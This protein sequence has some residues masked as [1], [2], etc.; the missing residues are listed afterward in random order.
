M[1]TTPKSL[2]L[3]IGI[4]GRTNTGKS[5]LLNLLAGQD[6]ALVSAI[7]GTTTDT[8]E[9]TM[10]LLPVGP[11]VFLDTAGID[12]T[13]ALASARI[14]RTKKALDRADVVLLV[15]E[16]DRWGEF[17]DRVVAD[18]QKR[19][20]P[21]VVAVNKSDIIPTTDE[22]KAQL[23]GKR[24]FF[25]TSAPG[26]DR[27]Q[28]LHKSKDLLIECV[29]EDFITPPPILGDLIPKHGF[30]A[31]VIPIDSQA[32]KGRI[33]LPQVQAIR[34]VLD[35]AAMCAVVTEAEY[36]AL[37][38]RL[39]APP[40]LTVCDSQ[41]VEQVVKDT[42]ADV[43]VT[44]FSILFARLKGDLTELAANT[45][46]MDKLTPKSKILVAESCTH[47]PVQ[48]DIGRQKIPRWVR[49]KVGKSV[50]FETA[51]GRDFP[52]DLKDY[53]LVIQ[54]G[55]CMQTRRDILLRISH[56]RDARVPITNYGL[57]ISWTK[58]VLERVLEPFPAAL[59]AYRAAAGK[60]K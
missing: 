15:I 41:A 39:N 17:E 4:F 24:H 27:D 60:G 16:G 45:A 25:V 48:D 7:A 2:R 53:D 58:G 42:P 36:P 8:V 11:I 35:H 50:K 56:A 1:K 18:A 40:D 57:A 9:K 32:P 6:A 22:V 29:P 12:D 55:G 14:S 21:L 5:S 23:E 47:H 46:A 28:Y 54:C 19:N 3:H 38:K 33:I 52:A 43:K 49:E 44:T 34:D 37:L 31:L 30:V 13:T 20:A 26:T 59:A 51:T 10:E